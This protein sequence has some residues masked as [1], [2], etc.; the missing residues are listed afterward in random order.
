[1]PYCSHVGSTALDAAGEDRVRR[2]LAAEALAAALLRDPLRLDD[3]LG[4]ERRAADDAHLALVHEVGQR[5]ERLVEVDG[6]SGRCIWYRS[7]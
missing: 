3:E 1:M 2:L 4:R 5:A 6:R 7:M